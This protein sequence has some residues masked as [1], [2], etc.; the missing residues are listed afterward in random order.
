MGKWQILTKIDIELRHLS[1]KI[2][3]FVLRGI[4]PETC[5]GHCASH[6]QVRNVHTKHVC[7]FLECT[8]ALLMVWTPRPLKKKM[9]TISALFK[10]KLLAKNLLANLPSVHLC[11]KV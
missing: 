3:L 6:E 5:Q 4:R 7:L 9:R 1:T 8:A 10:F 2:F 11:I